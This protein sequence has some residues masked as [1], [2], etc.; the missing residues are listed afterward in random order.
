VL[1]R[2]LLVLATIAVI[3]TS[4]G[5]L[6]WYLAYGADSRHSGDV[7]IDGLQNQVGIEW[8]SDDAVQIT[9]TGLPG[10][11]A[12][13]GY[14]H[15]TS[16][17]W[18]ILLYRQAALG[19]L[20][21]WFGAHA[22]QE[23]MLA[24]MLELGATSEKAFHLLSRQD[25]ILL[26]QYANGVNAAFEE[27]NVRRRKAIV[28]L[29]LAPEEWKPWDSI[30]VERLWAW[31]GAHT[32]SIVPGPTATGKSITSLLRYGDR[33]L[34]SRLHLFGFENSFVGTDGKNL[35]FRMVTGNSGRPPYLAFEWTSATDETLRGLSVPGTLIVPIGQR[36]SDSWGFLM[37]T[38]L[39]LSSKAG[40]PLHT[41]TKY[42]RMITGN[43]E[44]REIRI[45]R[46]GP[47]LPLIDPGES[48][49]EGTTPL[50]RWS[51]FDRMTD[52]QIWLGLLRGARYHRTLSSRLFDFTGIEVSSSQTV[53]TSGDEE[54][55]LAMAG[56][57]QLVGQSNLLSEIG[58]R[59]TG[60]TDST[61]DL[62]PWIF[63]SDN[64]SE[65]SRQ[66]VGHIFQMLARDSTLS[67]RE[68][69]AL[70]YLENWEYRFD[71][72]SIAASI[73]ETMDEQSEVPGRSSETD[74]EVR[75]VLRRTM[76]E[77]SGQFGYEM[78]AWRWEVV[79]KRSFAYPGWIANTDVSTSSRTVRSFW[80]AF[81]PVFSSRARGHPTTLLWGARRSAGPTDLYNRSDFATVSHLRSPAN[82]A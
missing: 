43:G 3:L 35:I 5:V 40:I 14:A 15:A 34:R 30:A 45:L 48:I 62:D 19:R 37:T 25:Q 59:A 33:Q 69:T 80:E 74:A 51:G 16:H 41:E 31:L 7:S 44:E 46:A 50:L 63:L 61:E 54:T 21:E 23:D 53:E 12:G 32:E 47:N 72:S 28:L 39:D 27:Q 66:M 4:I 6:F 49:R 79:Q 65:E 55:H 8:L 77:L 71:G 24:L 67:D 64:V 68:R 82:L 81:Q 60:L 42:D 2:L 17:A 52:A 70:N 22:E 26:Q 76:T 75:Q 36:N 9:G 57:W 13:L 73:V 56:G 20:S 78:S 38:S 58:I 29:G 10:F 18:E 1:T 11:A